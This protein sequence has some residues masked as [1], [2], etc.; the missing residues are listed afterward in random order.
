MAPDSAEAN[1]AGLPGSRP[2]RQPALASGSRRPGAPASDRGSPITCA[3]RS[4]ARER[5]FP[6]CWPS[7]SSSV[8]TSGEN[9]VIVEYLAEYPG[10]PGGCRRGS[11]PNPSRHG[12]FPSGR[13]TLAVPRRRRSPRSYAVPYLREGAATETDHLATIGDYELIEEIAGAAWGSCTGPVTRA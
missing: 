4:D 9:P 3:R 2:G 8:A 1:A 7:R 5:C 13:G 11:S 6:S 10:P 12:L